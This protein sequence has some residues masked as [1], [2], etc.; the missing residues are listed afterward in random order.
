MDRV[1]E[2]RGKEKKP[3]QKPQGVWARLKEKW[4]GVIE[5]R[6]MEKENEKR[7]A[8]DS[9][10]MQFRT[11]KILVAIDYGS[12]E[13]L[14][15]ADTTGIHG[16]MVYGE[17]LDLLRGGIVEKEKGSYKLSAYGE[18]LVDRLMEKEEI[19]EYADRYEI[20]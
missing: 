4:R 14:D 2:F 8:V 5:K 19:R 1:L 12:D 7:I 20:I 17:L 13:L 6:R 10:T 3:D 15:I 16:D 18:K 11:A 9:A